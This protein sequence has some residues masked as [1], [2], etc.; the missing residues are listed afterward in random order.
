MAPAKKH[1]P[2]TTAALVGFKDMIRD[3]AMKELLAQ[4]EERFNGKIHGLLARCK[5]LETEIGALKGRTLVLES[6]S[7]TPAERAAAR[8]GRI[9]AC[10]G[11]DAN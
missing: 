5:L 11:G 10:G 6:G 1:P 9:M 8:F 4:M 7:R 2:E 3:K